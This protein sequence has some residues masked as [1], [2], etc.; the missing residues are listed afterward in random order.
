MNPT[1]PNTRRLAALVLSGTMALTAAVAA[2]ALE[3]AQDDASVVVST[4]TDDLGTYLVGPDGLTL[5]YFTRDVTPGVSAC[6]GRC[7][8]A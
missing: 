5:Y 6:F 2:P 4:A 3:A 1:R 8:E 7:L